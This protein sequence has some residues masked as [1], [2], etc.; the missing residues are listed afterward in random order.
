VLMPFTQEVTPIKKGFRKY[1]SQE[2]NN[3]PSRSR[4]K[5]ANTLTQKLPD[6]EI[7]EQK[8]E[9]DQQRAAASAAISQGSGSNR[10]IIQYNNTS[11]SSSSIFDLGE[12]RGRNNIEGYMSKRAKRRD[13]AT[14]MTTI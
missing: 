4:G 8:K 5:R 12:R 3:S 2:S 14:T 13:T 11:T 10:N 1:K 9:I 6:S 7:L